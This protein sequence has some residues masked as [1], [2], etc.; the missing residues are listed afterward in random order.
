MHVNHSHS[1]VQSTRRTADPGPSPR[2]VLRRARKR[3]GLS[4]DDVAHQARIPR[5]YVVALE[6]G[7]VDVLPHGRFRSGYHRQ[8]RSFLGL[9]PVAEGHVSA[10]PS[11]PSEA[12]EVTGTTGTIPR[13]DEI[14]TF[15]LVASGF[16]F[17]LLVV[18][19]L[20]VGSVVLESPPAFLNFNAA[21]PETSESLAAAAA[22]GIAKAQRI[23]LR[24]IEDVRVS[25]TTTEGTI[26][27][28]VLPGGE[29]V[30]I[31]SDGPITLEIADLTRVRVRYNGSRLEPLHNLSKG[32]RLVFVPEASP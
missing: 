1:N 31:E 10:K 16:A 25:V 2:S 32:R 9:P 18:L 23:G 11:A 7:D 21:A 4:L 5:R 20:R 15:R 26:R 24:A 13:G 29:S 27:H 28:G 22:E 3:R 12:R 19:I 30:S 8:Y 14:P 6:R 17:T